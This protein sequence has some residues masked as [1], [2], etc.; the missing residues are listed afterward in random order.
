MKTSEKIAIS[1]PRDVLKAVE[2]QR[3]KRGE[4]RSA[5]FRRA[6]EDLLRRQREEAAVRRY[7]KGYQ[8]YPET[9]EEIKAAEAVAIEALKEEPWDAEG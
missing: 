1:L 8:K 9:E 2:T 5:F 7:I 4:T 6:A 3:K